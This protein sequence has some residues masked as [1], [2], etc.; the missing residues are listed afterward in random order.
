M[1]ILKCC[2]FLLCSL[3]AICCEKTDPRDV[4]P[5]AVPENLP[6]VENGK[7]VYSIAYAGAISNCTGLVKAISAKTGVTLG[8][9]L[10]KDETHPCEIILGRSY[11]TETKEAI[12]ALGGKDGYVIAASG[13]KLVIVG[14]NDTWTAL[15]LYYFQSSIL[16][17]AGEGSLSVASDYKYIVSYD[18]PMLLARLIKSGRAFSV[19]TAKVLD[20][21]GDNE[22][23]VA[24]GACCD[25]KYFYFANRNSGDTK[26][27]IYRYDMTT[28]GKAGNTAPFAGGHSNDMTF[29]LLHNRAIL[30]HGS[31]EGKILTPIDAETMAVGANINIT[32]GSGAISYNAYHQGYC[33]SQG[34]SSFYVTDNDFKV[35][36]SKSRTDNTGYTAQGMGSDDYFV[37]FPM[38][39]SKDNIL[40]V[41]DWEGKYVTTV[42]V[43]LS[44]E[45]E[46]MFYA[47]GNYYV[48]FYQGSSKGAA[49]YRL[50]PKMF[51]TP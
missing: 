47:N 18:N 22:C 37:Y 51:F 28:L 46:S 26:T 20:C 14:T 9:Y 31:T 32:V 43:P 2:F 34:G 44:I 29:D 15:A 49:L 24:Q 3:L 12:E 36:L 13:H 39:G 45:S 42:T 25:G 4:D 5:G 10:A 19:A 38:S 30:A 48:N 23:V 6:L 7:S 27:I 50:E 16:S 33:I 17:K 1:K 11:R 21:P 41:Y 8:T 40:V 35:K